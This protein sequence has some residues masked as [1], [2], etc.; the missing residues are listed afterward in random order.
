M[1]KNINIYNHDI[2]I[3]T[4]LLERAKRKY[5]LKGNANYLNW[6]NMKYYQDANYTIPADDDTDALLR[7]INDIETSKSDYTVYLPKGNYKVTQTIILQKGVCIKGDNAIIESSALIGIKIIDGNDRVNILEGVSLT[8]VGTTGSIG[9]SFE[10]QTTGSSNRMLHNVSAFNWDI[11]VK[12]NDNSYLIHFTGCKFSSCNTTIHFPSNIKNSGENISFTNC[13]LVGK[14]DV[15]L[16]ES[17]GEMQFHNCSFD[18]FTGYVFRL[19]NRSR[20]TLYG[21]H[22]E[23]NPTMNYAPFYLTGAGSVLQMYGG[24]IILMPQDGVDSLV[25]NLF[26]VYEITGPTCG[27]YLN[28]VQMDDIKLTTNYLC[29]ENGIIILDNCTHFQYSK[30]FKMLTANTSQNLLIDPAFQANWTDTNN[31][32][33]DLAYL[34]APS[35]TTINSWNSNSHIAVTKATNGGFYIQK[36]SSANT[37]DKFSIAVPIQGLK[38]HNAILGMYN[39]SLSGSVVLRFKYLRL[40]DFGDN[41]PLVLKTQEI[42]NQTIDIAT[43]TS[44]TKFLAN[45]SDYFQPIAPIWATHVAYEFDLTNVGSGNMFVTGGAFNEF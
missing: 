21:C 35:G 6:S 3:K 14:K 7:Y 18:Y 2:A 10:Q 28:G 32:T 12:F 20:V 22:I 4:N 45:T 41:K 31:R 42:C 38:R 15:V 17:F 11:D 37:A 8:G 29:G 44:D 19:T 5:G 24:T 13:T 30:T 36:F 39:Q 9:I 26:K 1:K 40:Q 34:T 33:R 23:T 27:V 43:V 25:P 16:M